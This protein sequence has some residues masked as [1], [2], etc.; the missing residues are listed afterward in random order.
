MKKTSRLLF[1]AII[2]VAMAATL[3]VGCKKEKDG[4]MTETADLS[5][6]TN[7]NMDAYLMA[8]KKKLLSA[9]KS[10]ET[11]SL[12]QAERD[13]GNLLNFDFGDANYATDVFQTDTMHA[14]LTLT[15]DGQV[16]LSQLAVTYSTLLS[17]ILDNYHN[18]ILPEKSVYTILC[19]F[20]E[21]ESKDADTRDVEI[22]VNTRGYTGDRRPDTDD[23][24]PSNLGG[25]CDGQ[26]IGGYGAPEIIEGWLDY[27]KILPVDC[28][29]GGRLYY[30]DYGWSSR[31]GYPNTYNPST[32][33]YDFYVSG[34]PPQYV[35]LTH[36]TM[37]YYCNKIWNYWNSRNFVPTPP[38]GRQPLH[39]QIHH[40]TTE[41]MQTHAPLYMWDVWVQYAK[42][43][44]TGTGPIH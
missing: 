35:C 9:E 43:H 10:D 34:W 18:T 5:A 36:D 26:L 15:S 24:R 7:D 42:P 39:F 31:A 13:L 4:R 1:A 8:F 27:E 28:I 16:D 41:H 20:H 19:N 25:M 30:T 12:E 3:F 38:S 32:G 21:T 37:V 29:N 17:E 44:C 40:V 23:W 33:G 11:I 6:S 14:N 2:I 22:I